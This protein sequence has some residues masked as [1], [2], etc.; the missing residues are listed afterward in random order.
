MVRVRNQLLSF[1]HGFQQKSSL[2]CCL[3]LLGYAAYYYSTVARVPLLG[4][5]AYYYSIVARVPLLGYAA[6]YYSTVE[7]YL[8]ACATIRKDTWHGQHLLFPSIDYTI[9][10]LQEDYFESNNAQVKKKICYLLFMR[11]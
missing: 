2:F 3:P 4:Y 7:N 6:Y 11:M 10:G 8:A 1:K 5:A 9:R